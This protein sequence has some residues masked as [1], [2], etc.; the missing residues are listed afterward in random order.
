MIELGPRCG[1]TSPKIGRTRPLFGRSPNEFAVW[2]RW[3]PDVVKDGRP[4][5]DPDQYLVADQRSY[6]PKICRAWA[7]FGRARPKFG[8]TRSE[9]ARSFIKPHRGCTRSAMARRRSDGSGAGRAGASKWSS[10][11]VSARGA[12]EVKAAGPADHPPD[13]PGHAG[14]GLS[15]LAETRGSGAGDEQEKPRMPHGRHCQSRRSQRVRADD[16]YFIVPQTRRESVVCVW[17]LWSA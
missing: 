7:K 15:D 11:R 6:Q 8:R 5:V 13:D 3:A 14:G 1:R 12:R 10:L 9:L 2:L 16:S 17:A 4:L